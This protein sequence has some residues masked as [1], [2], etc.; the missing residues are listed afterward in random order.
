MFRTSDAL[1][2][3]YGLAVTGT[4]VVT[5]ALAFFVVRRLWRWPLWAALALIGPLLSID[6][7]FPRRQP[8]KVAGRRLGAAGARHR[9]VRRD[10]DLD[11]RQRDLLDKTHRDSVPLPDLVDMLAKSS[12]SGSP[13]PRCS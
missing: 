4:M 6:V 12:R 7:G 9:D 1:A 13:E 2:N 3:A 5:T 11:A 10:V 8:L